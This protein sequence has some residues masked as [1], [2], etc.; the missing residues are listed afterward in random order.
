MKVNN[1][2]IH[3]GKTI[4]NGNQIV[5]LFNDLFVNTGPILANRIPK[6]D[7]LPW[8]YLKKCMCKYAVSRARGQRRI[9]H[10]F[11]IIQRFS[12]W[13]W[14]VI[15]KD[16]QNVNKCYYISFAACVKYVFV[17]WYISIRTEN[18]AYL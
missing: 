12:L 3:S 7:I 8:H 17:V 14:W 1:K 5:K 13:F 16:H 18:R 10:N 6:T 4:T 15:P 11:K 2:S 9:G